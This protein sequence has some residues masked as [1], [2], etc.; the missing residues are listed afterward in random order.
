MRIISF[1]RGVARTWLWG[2]TALAVSAC[3]GGQSGAEANPMK[4]GPDRSPDPVPFPPTPPSPTTPQPPGAPP[5]CGSRVGVV[6]LAIDETSLRQVPV[7]SVDEGEWP[8]I[9]DSD[10]LFVSGE[11]LYGSRGNAVWVQNGETTDDLFTVPGNLLHVELQERAGD[12]TFVAVSEF[13]SNSPGD[14]SSIP[15]PVAPTLSVN[16]YASVDGAYEQVQTAPIPHDGTQVRYVEFV[17]WDDDGNHDLVWATDYRVEWMKGDEDGSFE[18]QGQL[19]QPALTYL[20][21]FYVHDV[22]DD[23]SLDI[24]L[25][26]T[27]SVS[28]T[29]A[30]SV[31]LTS[32][33][34]DAGVLTEAQLDPGSSGLYMY[35]AREMAD[36]NG[37]GWDDV[38]WSDGSLWFAAGSASGLSAAQPLIDV[39][40]VLPEEPPLLADVNRDGHV[41]ILFPTLVL[42]H[43]G[44]TG[45][46]PHELEVNVGTMASLHALADANTAG[47]VP[48]YGLAEIPNVCDDHCNE[49]ID[50][51]LGRCVECLASTDCAE[52]DGACAGGYCVECTA[53]S[54]CNDDSVCSAERVCKR[55]VSKDDDW[56]LIL[57][58][59][60][61]GCGLR[62][63]G[64]L[65]CWGSNWDGAPELTLVDVALSS[66]PDILCGVE[67]DGDLRCFAGSHFEDDVPTELP[68]GPFVQVVAADKTMCALRE[69]GSIACFTKDEQLDIDGDFTHLSAAGAKLCALSSPGLI[70]C[71]D[72]QGEQSENSPSVPTAVPSGDGSVIQMPPSD[73]SFVTF[74]IGAAGGCGIVGGDPAEAATAS[75]PVQCWGNIGAPPAGTFTDVAVGNG[76]CGVHS[77]GR[78]SCWGQTWTP[79]SSDFVSLHG[80]GIL[81]GIRSDGHFECNGSWDGEAI[82]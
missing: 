4:P 39:S 81:C 11:Q 26:G 33:I 35:A 16:V 48:V 42:L 37:D 6:R 47:E 3:A 36:V 52:S 44:Q 10:R 17:D 82:P 30:L 2:V 38:V 73:V 72:L 67:L 45:F 71:W 79:R 76:A 61:A 19:V 51:V 8:T 46:V 41:D 59:G 22:N 14:G 40:I 29:G 9:R 5:D 55:V 43:D 80:D 25:L 21:G 31:V 66:E 65:H 50:E 54:H 56:E 62:D 60:H 68:D 75:G 63:G 74:D 28:S 23:G 32:Y 69:S 78:P 13:H 58:G 57:H 27:D 70:E 15:A 49:E 34:A 20:H 7:V 64:Q 24:T 53:D 12:P 18:A 1:R 77:D